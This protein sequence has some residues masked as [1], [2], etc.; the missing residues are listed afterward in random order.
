MNKMWSKK[1]VE[2]LKNYYE[3]SEKNFL[4]N[5]LKRSWSSIVNKAF[6]LNLNR[7][8]CD[9]EKLMDESLDSYYWL[10]LS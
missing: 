4:L 5:H 7:K 8:N 3:K 2:F 6:L 1:E 9:I 10:G